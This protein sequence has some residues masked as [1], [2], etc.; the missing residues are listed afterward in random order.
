MLFRRNR[1]EYSDGEIDLI[2]IHIG[3][4][5]RELALGH[6]QIWRITLHDQKQEIGQISYRD[7]EGRNVY[8]FGHIGY[9]I[10]PPYRGNEGTHDAGQRIMLRVL[11]RLP[12]I[13]KRQTGRAGIDR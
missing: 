1:V 4:L 13:S 12:E 6:E 5:N 2:P 7:G 11:K 8:F 3:V 10:D 9:H